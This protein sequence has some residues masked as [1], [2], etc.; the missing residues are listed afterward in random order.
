MQDFAGIWVPLV[1]PFHNGAV[2]HDGLKRLV[3]HLRGSGITGLVVCGSTGEAAS[4]DEAEQ[5]AVLHTA[6]AARGSSLTEHR[7]PR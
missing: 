5:L 6:L 7:M 1:T 2:D 4:L 3:A